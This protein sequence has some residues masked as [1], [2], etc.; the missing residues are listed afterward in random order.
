MPTHNV[1]DVVIRRL[2][3]YLRCLT[4]MAEQGQKLVS[5]A[6]L[7]AWAGA[8]PAQ[9]RK[10]LSYF[11][12]FGTQGLGYDVNYLR[13]QIRSI[14]QVDRDWH[15][16]LVGAGAL[17]HALINYRTFEDWR[18]HIVAVLDNDPAKA[19]QP[20]GELR[21]QPMTE[22]RQAIVAN[23]V[24]IAV[25]AIPAEQAQ[26]VAEELVACGVRAILN[27]A[28]I[29]LTLPADVPISYIDPLANLQSITYYL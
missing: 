18:Y 24:E 27:Y 21:V 20:I 7:G 12:G 10:D 28:P 5:S 22:M 19:G 4:R 23:H 29:N 3:L 11:G 13:A 17:G 14:L 8:S 6:D 2:P 15:I 16:V 1:P 26:Q 25:L 9:I